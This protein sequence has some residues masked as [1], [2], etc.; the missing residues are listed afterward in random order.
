MPQMTYVM[1]F[2]INEQRRVQCDVI[3]KKEVEVHGWFGKMLIL[4]W[5]EMLV[6]FYHDRAFIQTVTK[7]LL[8]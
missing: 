1:L 2:V 7:W 4:C 3:M 8:L 5:L 6:S